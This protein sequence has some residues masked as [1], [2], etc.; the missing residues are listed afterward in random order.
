MRIKIAILF[1]L[2][3]CTAAGCRAEQRTPV[4]SGVP[5]VVGLSLEDAK[6]VLD[7][8]GVAYYVGT[9]NGQTPIIDHLWEVCA[10]DP[11][12]GADTWEVDLDVD[13]EC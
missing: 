8:A 3:V 1:L 5:D 10:Q 11:A 2:V 9:P 13:R 7:D 4:R 12:P 6:E